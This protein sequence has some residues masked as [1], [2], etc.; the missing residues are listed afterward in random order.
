MQVTPHRIAARNPASWL[1]LLKWFVATPQ[2]LK[3]YIAGL[4]TDGQR[5]LRQATTWIVTSLCFLPLLV[6]SAYAGAAP[7][8]MSRLADYA[9]NHRDGT[10]LWVSQHW[11]VVPAALAICWVSSVLFDFRSNHRIGNLLGAIASG[12][13]TLTAALLSGWLLG[14]LVLG[15]SVAPTCGLAIGLAARLGSKQ[16][17]EL[18]IRLAAG[19]M[20]GVIAAFTL[21]LAA[22]PLAISLLGIIVF[23]AQVAGVYKLLD[24]QYKQ[25]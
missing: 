24:M 8:L 11:M 19:L 15:L 21:G 6:L 1:L 4:T 10:T 18:T 9:T 5:E 14:T 22:D 25:S 23:G 17:S 2:H 13:G 20:L 3:Q 7:G 12:L 16:L